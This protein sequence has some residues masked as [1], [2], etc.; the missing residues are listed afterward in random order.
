M[1][2]KK[3]TFYTQKLAHRGLEVTS[4]A[5]P[6]IHRACRTITTQPKTI[7]KTQDFTLM[8]FTKPFS[9]S[10]SIQL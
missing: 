1:V 7:R 9:K 2:L 6:L 4:M 3:D 8:A 5:E 10:S